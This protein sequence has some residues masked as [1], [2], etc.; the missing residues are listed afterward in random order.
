M[1]TVRRKHN[2]RMTKRIHQRYHRTK[3]LYQYGGVK[4]QAPKSSTQR[5]YK[6]PSKK[7]KAKGRR[8]DR[9]ELHFSE[10]YGYIIGDPRLGP[11]H[12][13]EKARN[14]RAV[15]DIKMDLSDKLK[16]N[17][18]VKSLAQTREGQTKFQICAAKACTFVETLL[19]IKTPLEMAIIIRHEEELEKN[20]KSIRLTTNMVNL[21]AYLNAL[22]GGLNTTQRQQIL[23]QIQD[24]NK[25]YINPDTSRDA[26][27][28]ID[29][30]N[31]YLKGIG[32]RL[33]L[34]PKEANP[35]AKR[36]A[37]LQAKF[38]YDP[39][40]PRVVSVSRKVDLP[41]LPLSSQSSQEMESG[42]SA[43]APAMQS[44]LF[45]FTDTPSAASRAPRA[46]SAAPKASSAASRKS[47]AAL[48]KRSSSAIRVSDLNKDVYLVPRTGIG[49]RRL[50][51][52][53]E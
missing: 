28:E 1:K 26:R 45:K 6:P 13:V 25:R 32:A 43:P 10:Q 48:S 29:A 17:I 31:K 4:S 23:E 7:A 27:V 33:Q 19:D 14:P 35:E 12:R 15:Y 52:I 16:A 53:A 46:S 30:L 34:A 2:R 50:P 22:F 9:G 36:P 38:D 11:K 51:P 3:K 37:R 44:E 24:L 5:S 41:P 42:E 21:H 40:S 39:E 18:S 47:S 20:S 8:G 49:K